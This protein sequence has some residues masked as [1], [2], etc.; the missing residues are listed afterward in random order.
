M[1]FDIP[2]D[3]IAKA[4]GHTM[5]DEPLD[6]NCL[7]CDAQMFNGAMEVEGDAA[8]DHSDREV[9]SSCCSYAFD[10][11]IRRCACGAGV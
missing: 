2:Y 4:A 3:D 6:W 9:L 5:T 1:K 11:D 8:C 7:E 10:P